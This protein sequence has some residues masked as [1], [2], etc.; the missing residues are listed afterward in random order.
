[1]LATVDHGRRWREGRC[2]GG[3]EEA[4]VTPLIAVIAALAAG[5]PEAAP[6]ADNTVAPVEVQ[7]R[8]APAMDPSRVRA[9]RLSRWS[10]TR[11]VCRWMQQ[12]G[13]GTVRRYCATARAWELWEMDQRSFLQM[14]IKPFGNGG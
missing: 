3:C 11:V 4:P 10:K 5:A 13:I 12:P 8:K 7:G 9:T 14:W 6:P 1:M 2:S